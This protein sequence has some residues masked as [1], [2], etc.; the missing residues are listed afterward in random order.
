MKEK[1]DD[2][3][4]PILAVDLIVDGSNLRDE[5]RGYAA[6]SLKSSDSSKSKDDTTFITVDSSTKGRTPCTRNTQNQ[7]PYVCLSVNC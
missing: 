2:E 6:K 4:E 7:F 1:R 3:H 5:A